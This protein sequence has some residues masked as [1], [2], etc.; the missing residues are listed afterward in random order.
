MP[1]N[2]C[3]CI[4]QIILERKHLGSSQK[5]VLVKLCESVRGALRDESL[6]SKVD[7]LQHVYLC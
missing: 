6:F 1:V 7:G 5:K 2:G 3:W 4:Y